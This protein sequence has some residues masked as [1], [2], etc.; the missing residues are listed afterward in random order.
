MLRVAVLAHQGGWDEMLF[1][2]VPILLFVLL[3]RMANRRADRQASAAAGSADLDTGAA[4]RST[5]N[6]NQEATD[7]GD[8]A[9]ATGEHR[10]PEGG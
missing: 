1:V 8:S 3:L 6:G 2:A 10:T 7:E 5:D 4:A 9:P